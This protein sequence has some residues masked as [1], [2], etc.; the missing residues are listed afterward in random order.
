MPIFSNRSIA[1]MLDHVVSVL[2]PERKADWLARL[3]KSADSAIAAE[4]EIAV[5][6]CLAK[7]GTIE[8]APRREGVRDLEVIYTSRSTGICVAIEVT[9]VSDRY[10]YDVNP[11]D[12]FKEEVLRVTFK[13]NIQKIDG[14]RYDIGNVR[15][16][17]GPILGLPPANALAGFFQS[18]DVSQ[19]IANIKKQPEQSHELRFEYN[20]AKSRLYFVPGPA[21]G[22]GGH[23]THTL[24][25][26]PYKNPITSRLDEKDKQIAKAK[27]DLPAVIVLCDADSHALHSARSSFDAQSAAQVIHTFLNVRG[28]SRRINGVVIWPV[29]SEHNPGS[30][31]RPRYFT[32]PKTIKTVATTHF[33]LNDRTLVDI[34]SAASHLPRIARAPVNA[35]RKSKWPPYFGGCTILPGN[36]M[37]IRMSLLS[38]QYLLSGHIPAG[39]FAEA[40]ADLMKQFKL[41]TDR[42]LIISAMDIER[43][44]DEDDDWVEIKLEQTAPTHILKKPPAA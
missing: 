17:R 2:G 6:Y 24:L 41:A 7:Q 5:L 14:I 8:A 39:K 32:I 9:A 27:L 43:S 4:W 34:G 44:T 13:H 35:R 25:F 19:F 26:D 18:P 37:K 30:G 12:R 36:P 16:D 15:G 40:N 21:I 22:G 42:G 23:T 10:Y 33:A 29:F 20:Q 1:G 3:N 11:T 31:K 28:Q 38:L